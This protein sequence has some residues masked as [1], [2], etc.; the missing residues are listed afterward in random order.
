M[1][2]AGGPREGVLAA[3]VSAIAGT[4]GL[5]DAFPGAL[6]LTFAIA[7]TAIGLAWLAARG[8]D[9]W[10]FY[11][12]GMVVSPA[13]VAYGHRSEL[14]VAR[15]LIVSMALWLLLAGRLLGWLASR[16]R[17]ARFVVAATLALFLVANAVRTVPLLRYGRG[18]FRDALR[19]MQSRTSGDAVR[20]I[21][22]QDTRNAITIDYHA[23]RI[24]TD[25]PVRYVNRRD[26]TGAGSDWYI[27]CLPPPP[28]GVARVVTDGRGNQYRFEIEFPSNPFH[29][30]SW[31]LYRRVVTARAGALR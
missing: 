19:Y 10:I 4:T 23:P 28:G 25:R 6:L 7:V 22:D 26:R 29:G 21:G 1:K 2:S 8:S 18:T 14:Y 20:V 16:G 17:R 9:L 11:L 27:A 15:H 24:G 5:P 31:R 12:F 3:A 30:I 13:V